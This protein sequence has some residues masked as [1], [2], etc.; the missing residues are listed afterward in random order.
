MVG[1]QCIRQGLKDET[2][3]P[4]ACAV[5]RCLRVIYDG[6]MHLRFNYSLPDCATSPHALFFCVFLQISETI[7][8]ANDRE[9][10][11]FAVPLR[12][13]I[14]VRASVSPGG[15]VKTSSPLIRR[16]PPCR[17]LLAGTVAIA[18]A[19]PT[20]CGSS[21]TTPPKFSGN[22]A[23]V[24]L[25]SGT[26]NDQLFQF[27]VTLQSLTLTSQSG[28]TVSL[29]TTPASKPKPSRQSCAIVVGLQP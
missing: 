19:F 3:I 13:Q 10:L 12:A 20:G 23:V 16:L 2:A 24:V 11:T 6:S 5:E 18:T 9:T 8:P 17:L 25:A 22:T 4:A 21:G 15:S 26:A 7:A 27:S 14:F 28:K 29:L 1:G